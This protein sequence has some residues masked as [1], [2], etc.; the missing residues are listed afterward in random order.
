M[1]EM[2]AILSH[3]P[4][5]ILT[6]DSFPEI[7]DIPE[8]G[9]TLKENAFI[10][11]ET[12]HKITGLPALADDTGLE[13]DAL[14]GAPGVFSARYAGEDATFFDNCTKLIKELGDLPSSKRTARFRTVISFVKNEKKLW[15]EGIVEGIILGH[16]KGEGGF[17]YDSIFY[18]PKLKKTF[19][20]LKKDEKN[21][22]SHRGQALRKFQEIL[23][24]RI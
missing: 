1:E 21:N 16:M 5:E 2:S 8:T 10:K 7:G 4:I 20:E 3:L 12:V 15:T 18:Y 11:A 23:E 6:L 17:G 14:N 9:E 22:I 13:V 24:N 19:A